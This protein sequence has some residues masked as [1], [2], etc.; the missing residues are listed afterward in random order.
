LTS[1]NTLCVDVSFVGFI[2]IV[3]NNGNESP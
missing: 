3:E 2:V 1:K